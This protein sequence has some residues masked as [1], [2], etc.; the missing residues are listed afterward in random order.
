MDAR[1]ETALDI[2]FAAAFDVTALLFPL[3]VRFIV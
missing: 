3:G 2:D 1:F